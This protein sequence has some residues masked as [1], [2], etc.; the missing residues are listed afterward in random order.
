MRWSRRFSKRPDRA[1]G[2]DVMTLESRLSALEQ[3]A[4]G[5]DESGLVVVKVVEVDIDGSERVRKKVYVDP[6]L[7]YTVPAPD[8]SEERKP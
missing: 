4:D 7:N 6:L 2:S 8:A 5:G 1:E 3:L